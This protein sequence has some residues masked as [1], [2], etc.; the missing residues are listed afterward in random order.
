MHTT[1]RALSQRTP[2]GRVLLLGLKFETG[3]ENESRP[4]SGGSSSGPASRGLL[5]VWSVRFMS[6]TICFSPHSGKTAAPEQPPPCD[7][8]HISRVLGAESRAWR[9]F[10][11][12]SLTGGHWE[13]PS[14]MTV[15]TGVSWRACCSWR[16]NASTGW[17]DGNNAADL[18]KCVWIFIT[19]APAP[20]GQKT[21]SY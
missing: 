12:P 21:Q 2:S 4:V 8:A 19:G 1:L 18:H 16:I 10:S 11:A 7:C 17:K 13:L 15:I 20:A 3:S 14:I 5:H 6:A 9:H